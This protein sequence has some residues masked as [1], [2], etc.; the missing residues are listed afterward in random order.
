MIK[1]FSAGDIVNRPF[2][3]FKNWHV[4]SVDVNGVDSHGRSTYVANSGEVNRG[5]KIDTPFYPSGS[6]RYNSNLEPMTPNGKYERMVYSLTDSMFYRN[7]TNPTELFGLESIERDPRTG[8]KEVRE[9]NDKVVTLRIAENYWGEKI[10][11][12]S[13]KIVDNSFRHA[14]YEI[15]DDGMTNLYIT[16]AYFGTQM[17]LNAVNPLPPTPKWNTSSISYYTI[18]ND[19]TRSISVDYAKDLMSMGV[20]VGFVEN[21]SSN[22]Q[23]DYSTYH[24]YYQPE[25]ERFGQ[26]VSSWYK[27]IA[28]G[29]PVDSDSLTDDKQGYSALFK[30]DEATGQ[31]RLIKRMYSPYSDK[32]LTSEYDSDSE[33]LS[34][35]ESSSANLQTGSYEDGFGYSVSVKDNFLAVGAPEDDSGS[36]F[37]YDRFKGGNDNWGLI[38]MLSGSETNDRFGNAVSIDDDILAVGSPGANGNTGKVSIFR[39]KRYM[40]GTSPCRSIPTGSSDQ[41]FVSGNFAW[42]YEAT[43]T[44]SI[45]QT[46]D[47]FGWVLEANNNKVIVGNRKTSGNGYATLFVC[48]YISA[49]IGACPTASWIESLTYT[50]NSDLGDLDSSNPNYSVQASLAYDGFGWSV[51]LNGDCLAVGSYYDK[52]VLPY[53]GAPLQYL[54]ILGAVYFYHLHVNDCD[55][56][57]YHLTQK[58]FGDVTHTSSNLFGRKISI[59]GLNAAITSEPSQTQYS[60]DFL[61]SY[62]LESSSYQSENPDDAVLGRVSMYAFGTDYIWDRV[63]EVRRNKEIDS[64]FS[65]FGRGISLSTDFLVVG[66]PI[67]NYA[68]G[69]DTSSI[70]DHN[71]QISESFSSKYSGSVY[72]YDLKDYQNNTLIGNAF[73]KNGYLVVTNT[74]SNYSD[75]LTGTSSYGFDMKYQGTHTIYENE[76]LISIRP[77]EFN[78]STNP[79]S[80]INNSLLFD[81]NQDGIFDFADLDL[82]MRY[83]VKKR[84]YEEYEFDDNG[85]VLEQDNRLSAWWNNEILLTEAGD[86]LLQESDFAAFLVNSAFTA[87]T[88]K[89]YNY[90]E[91]N[92]VST[93]ILDIDGN[94]IVDINDGAILAAYFTEKLTPSALLKWIGDNSKRRYVSDIEEYIG[95]YTGEQKFYTNPNFFS[96]QA[97][98]SYD[99][100]GSYLAPYITTIGLYDN[101]RLVGVGKLGRPIKNLIDWPINFIVR[102]DT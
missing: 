80:L 54:K 78:Y 88:K 97:S 75:I 60:V 7:S 43:L 95:K 98:S 66:A 94:G 33:I 2:K 84:F 56:I 86:V 96:Y 10:V 68:T 55:V 100:T 4:Q 28:V 40:D 62:V 31:H 92:L 39:L 48:N 29:S 87:F 5:K 18:I 22:W 30:Y 63:G 83:L 102:F 26:S 82:I 37:I 32:E 76:Y 38:S 35:L 21:T 57:S 101:N 42:E 20:E 41:L 64:P 9:I 44:S 51:A 17:M 58:T 34:Q 52:G 71:T 46:G 53:S 70:Y 14:T 27:Y 24:D 13:I 72:V 99:P 85:I 8:K 67:Y 91:T 74:S 19:A 3:T 65:V 15:Y 1:Q 12:N 89:A 69:S 45:S 49:S 16:G 36:V 79:T 73:Y 11:P 59:D 50:S 25:N 6:P 61:G 93:G 23:W 47:N 90:I 77:G 81:V